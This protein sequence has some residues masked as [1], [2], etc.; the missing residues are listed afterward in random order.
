MS[1]TL[2]WQDRDVLVTGAGG[3][4]GSHLAEE[5]ARRG[6]HVRA[7]VR[8]GSTGARGWLGALP[9]ELQPRVTTV[10]ADVRDARQVNAAAEGCSVVFHLAALISIPYSYEA[11]ESYLDT[12]VRGT[13][14]VLDACLR[15]GVVRLVHTSTSEVYGSPETV[16]ITEAHPLKAQSPYAA[17][18][19]AADQLALSYHHSFGVPVCV[20]RPFNTYGPRQSARA[21]LPTILSQLLA[22]KE[23]LTLGALWPRRDLTYVSDTV[24][25]FLKAAESEAAVGHTVQLGTGRDVSIGELAEIAMAVTGRRLQIVCAEERQ[26]PAGSEV[27]Q[28]LSAPERAHTLLGWE[29]TISLEDGIR[30]TAEWVG[31]HLASFEVD[32]YRV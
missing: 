4:I 5:L 21:V 3:F 17:T 31:A 25:G 14:N 7:M 26:R 10:F 30:R 24:A 27:R 29:P 2:D 16:P 11:P 6:A 15:Q 32:R 22:G 8:Y 19:V 18:K 13:M 12:N 1:K 9:A 20:L 23:Q 28:L